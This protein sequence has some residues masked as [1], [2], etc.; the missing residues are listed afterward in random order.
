MSCRLGWWPRPL[1]A[2]KAIPVLIPASALAL[3]RVRWRPDDHRER[4]NISKFK[5]L[6]EKGEQVSDG[7]VPGRP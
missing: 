1:A 4:N 6:N 3:A 2:R 5:A 7:Q